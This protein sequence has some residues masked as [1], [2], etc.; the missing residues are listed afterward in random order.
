MDLLRTI[1]V[2]TEILHFIFLFIE[3]LNTK[4]CHNCAVKTDQMVQISYGGFYTSDMRDMKP[5]QLGNLF[6]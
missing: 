2:D 3:L 5:A 6:T 1:V 4:Q